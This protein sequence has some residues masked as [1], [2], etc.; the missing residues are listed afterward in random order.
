[1][2]SGLGALGGVG[3]RVHRFV[4]FVA[5]VALCSV[6]V[7]ACTSS[8]S[9]KKASTGATANTAAPQDAVRI[10]LITADLSFLTEQ[11]LAPDI[12]DPTK[13]A[14]A[15]VDDINAKGGVAGKQL[16]LTTRTIP[17]APTAT[18]A[19]LQQVC[20]QGT[21][22]DKPFAVIVTA[23]VPVTVVQCSAVGHSLLTITMDAWQQ[24]IYNDAKGRLFAVGTNGSADIERQ[25]GFG[26]TMLRSRH[27]L[28]G[29][30]VG[31]LNQDQPADRAP[32]A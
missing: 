4:R 32:A 28:D 23:A 1:M 30:T 18:E 15:V 10:S 31:I 17:N 3:F 11:H 16:A 21:E 13:V 9:D 7:A 8:S 29:K 5:V 25:Y 2:D 6:T 22:E 20:V 14:K 12:G 26:P 19:V 27:A 24:A